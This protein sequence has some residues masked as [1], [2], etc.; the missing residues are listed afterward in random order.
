[1]KNREQFKRLLTFLAS[2]IIIALFGFSFSEVWNSQY[3]SEMLDPYWYN[4]NILMVVIYVMVY[5]LSA[6]SFSGFR[7]GYFKIPSLIGSQ[8]LGILMTNAITF[9]EIS[10]I[11]RGRLSVMPILM[12]TGVEFCVAVLWSVIFTKLFASI[13]PPRKMIIV[14]GNRSAE[15]LVK[16]MSM[17]TDK[18][19]INESISCE[20]DIELIE[21][22]ILEHDA[23]VVNDVPSALK[24]RLL[25][26]TFENDIRIYINPKLSDILVRG[27]DDCN[28]FDTPLLLRRNDGLSFDQAII[29][30]FFDILLS[31]IMLIIASP[32]MLVTAIA[33]KL[34]DG[35][36]VLYSQER[37]TQNGK[38][39]KVHKFRSMIVNAEK[40]GAQLAGKNDDRITPVGKI[41][42]KIR[43]DELPQLIN[44]LSGDM[45]FVGPRPERPELAEKYEKDMPEFRY[46]LKVKAGLTGYAQVMGKYNTT[47]YD[48][49]KLDL[50]YIE[51]QSFLLDLQ[52]MLMTVK[53]CFVP[54]ATEGVDGD[55]IQ[56]K[57]EEHTVNTK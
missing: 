56:T 3:N 44:I 2:F 1:M 33:I 20:E 42:R 38:I 50:M 37:L 29:K 57:R 8:T 15:Q 11:G 39:F 43:F 18:Y 21:Q 22:R 45:S 16:K 48:K 24:N 51:R 52:L 47:P 32:F 35:G 40:H 17:R 55:V 31:L 54:D 23:V 30:R 7:I 12:L 49:L 41:I 19:I 5:V 34:Y 53:I 27:A 10:L 36:P 46:R 25:K 6:N 13:Y 26:F 14:Y 28:L 9:L 4:G